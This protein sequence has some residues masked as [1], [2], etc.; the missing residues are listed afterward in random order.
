MSNIKRY[1]FAAI[2]GQENA[3]LALLLALI[4]PKAGGLLISG[5]KGTAKST[6]V[7]SAASLVNPQEIVTVPLNVTEDM[8]FGSIDVEYA[9]QSATRTERRPV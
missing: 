5:E 2:V 3:K 9:L 4:N 6:L 7:H 8:L 1:P